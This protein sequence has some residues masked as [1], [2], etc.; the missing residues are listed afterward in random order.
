M[1]LARRLALAAAAALVAATIAPAAGAHDHHSSSTPTVSTLVTFAAPGCTGPCGSGSTIGPDGALYVTDGPGGRVLRIDRQ[2]G[3]TTTYAHGLPPTI[4][5]VGI[6]GAIDVIFRDG[7]GYVLVSVVG[8]F[9]GQTGVV[10][11]IYRINPDGTGTPVADIGAWSTAHPP[12]GF[13]FEVTSGVQYA[14]ESYRGGFLVTDGHLNR[15]LWVAPDWSIHQVV[16][17]GD[18]VPTGLER[19]GHHVYVAQ[20]GPVPHVPA[21][22][23]VLSLDVADGTTTTVAS[24]APLL[25]D[26]ER[27]PAHQLY[28][29]SQG[30]WT[31]PN[32]PENAGKPASPNT[33][34]LVRVDDGALEPVVSGLDRPTSMEIRG[35]TA[36]VVTMTGTVVKISNL[37]DEHD[38]D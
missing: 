3:A 19:H 4:G 34:S 27:G 35:H 30:L 18:I 22:G 32:L 31:W 23:K 6:G 38:D 9:F 15:V 11:G 8:P 5:A 26:V 21:T 1:R 14:L 16:Q 33:G 25:V 2:T 13:A 20:A 37:P 29:L 7:V 28:A 17:Y 12:T 36:Y 10:D 24:G